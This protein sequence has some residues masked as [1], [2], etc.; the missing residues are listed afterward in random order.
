MYKEI[1]KE[2]Q[3]L[4]ETIKQNNVTIKELTDKNNKT[5]LSYQELLKE[6]Q[7]LKE[8]IKELNDEINK[9]NYE[10]NIKLAN[11]QEEL[12]IYDLNKKSNK[13]YSIKS[14]NKEDELDILLNKA[15]LKIISVED[16]EVKKIITK[17]QNI[18]DIHKKRINQVLIIND[19]LKSLIE[20]NYS[21]NN[22]LLS[23]K[24]DTNTNNSINNRVSSGCFCD[25]KNNLT[26][27]YLINQL[28]RK[29][30]IIQKYKE[31]DEEGEIKTQELIN[32]NNKL[33]ESY[34][35]SLNKNMGFDD[36]LTGKIVNDQKEVLGESSSES[37]DKK[38][39]QNNKKIKSKV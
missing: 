37:D 14:S 17:I 25:K 28:K 5:I 39:M 3:I 35:N 29:D 7:L 32:E 21:L 34:N 38:Y 8:K 30:E 22:Q 18:K 11:I 15:L 13:N 20:E 33:M 9:I 6:N 16:E 10:Q 2:N 36:Y 27:D 12:K 4:K 24:K 26:Y 1:I 23:T 31:Q 19:K